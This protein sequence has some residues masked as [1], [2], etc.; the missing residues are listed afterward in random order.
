[1]QVVFGVRGTLGVTNEPVAYFEALPNEAFRN[2][3]ITFDAGGSYRYVAPRS[4]R[5][6]PESRLSFEWD[7][8]DGQT[9]TGRVVKH[10][11]RA[12]GRY[13]ATLT[14][15]Q[16][17]SGS[18]AAQLTRGGGFSGDVTLAVTGLPTGVTTTITPPQLSGTTSSATIN[19]AV[20]ATGHQGVDVATRGRAGATNTP[21]MTVAF[22]SRS[23]SARRYATLRRVNMQRG[24][25]KLAL[26]LALVAQQP[27]CEW[28]R[29]SPIALT[30]S[31]IG[32][33]GIA[34]IEA[35]SFHDVAPD[36]RFVSYTNW[37]TGNLVLRD[38]ETGSDSRL[39]NSAPG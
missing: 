30:Q 9:A 4:R 37:N 18:V 31:K 39:T 5:L 32:D 16:G 23:L 3:R 14:V 6:A 13:T 19:V 25:G 20:A 38:L 11:Y 29:N 35:V 7:F 36:G 12:F 15:P 33:F 10:A 22:G 17:G 28:H 8:G 27:A 21:M 2:Q 24:I 34:G 26:A 1:M